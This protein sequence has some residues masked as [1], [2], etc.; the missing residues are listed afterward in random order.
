[1]YTEILWDLPSK[2]RA[3]IG[4]ATLITAYNFALVLS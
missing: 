4:I 2:R 1:M 3:G